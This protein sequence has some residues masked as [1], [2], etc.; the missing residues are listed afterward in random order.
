MANF[1]LSFFWPPLLAQLKQ[2]GCNVLF[3]LIG[4]RGELATKVGM[5]A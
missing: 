3:A 1:F 4:M 2:N 5:I